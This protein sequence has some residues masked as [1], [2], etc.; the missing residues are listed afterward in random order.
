MPIC[1]RKPRRLKGTKD[2]ED[3]QNGQ[4]FTDPLVLPDQ[5][6]TDLSVVAAHIG[7]DV[8]II[9]GADDVITPRCGRAAIISPRSRRRIRNSSSIPNAGHFAFMTS[10]AFLPALTDKVRP[11]AIARGA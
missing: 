4:L 9:Q 7:T 1:A 6:K 3:D 2:F 8:F 11:V 10:D 5:V